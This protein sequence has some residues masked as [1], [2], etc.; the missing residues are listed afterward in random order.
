MKIN[1]KNFEDWS[2]EDLRTLLNNE[3]F[4]EGQFLDYKRT[5]DF[6]EATEKLQRIKGKIEFC[7]DVCSFANADGGELIFG[8]AEKDGFASGIVSV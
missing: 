6:L 7:N 4:R 8:I 5:F 1:N 2:E 3:D